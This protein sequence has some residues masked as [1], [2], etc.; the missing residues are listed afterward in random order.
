MT[1]EAVLVVDQDSEALA[2]VNTNAFSMPVEEFKEVLDRCEANR[3][4]FLGRVVSKFK[5]KTHFVVIKGKKSLCKPGAEE[6]ANWFN[7]TYA[8]IKRDD[9]TR[10]MFAD[11]EGVLFY[12]CIFYRGNTPIS[13][14]RG[15]RDIKTEGRDYNKCIKMAQKSAYIDAAMRLGGI[16]FDYTQDIESMPGSSIQEVKVK[17]IPN[18]TSE[19]NRVKIMDT[20]SERN[21]SAEQFAKH[22]KKALGLDPK[23]LSDEEA[24]QVIQEADLFEGSEP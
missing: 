7:V 6:I 5:E 3:S 10:E 11:P 8:E 21:L 23:F 18:A 16:S 9:E 17:P 2:P 20:I 12:K 4:E 24:E 14:G 22:I 15:A 13:E 1:D 19:A